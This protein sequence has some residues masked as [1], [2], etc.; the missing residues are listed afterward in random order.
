M[1]IKKSPFEGFF[2]YN[3]TINNFCLPKN[4][5]QKYKS[6]LYAKIIKKINN[7]YKNLFVAKKRFFFCNSFGGYCMLKDLFFKRQNQ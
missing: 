2:L 5:Y 6:V 4:I 7:L 1:M 3:Q